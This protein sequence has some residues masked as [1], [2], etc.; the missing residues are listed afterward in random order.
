M[1]NTTVAVQQHEDQNVSVKALTLAIDSPARYVEGGSLLSVINELIAKAHV[2]HD[3]VCQKT[4]AAWQEALDLRSRVVD[5]LEKAKAY[6]AHALGRYDDTQRRL[7][8][9]QERL[10]REEQERQHAQE[11]EEQMQELDRAGASVEEVESVLAQPM[12][13]PAPIVAPN[14]PEVKGLSTRDYWSAEFRNLRE[15]VNA[16][17]AGKAPLEAVVFNEPYINGR[18]RVEKDK[19]N[20]PGVRAVKTTKASSRR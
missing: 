7:A 2:E 10:A 4:R 14:V 18:A 12:L 13:A 6:L 17:V 9:E 5:P 16:I 11:I 20:I 19:L 3:P 1:S 15:L 8:R